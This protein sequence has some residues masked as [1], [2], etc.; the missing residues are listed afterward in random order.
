MGDHTTGLGNV[1]ID[2][3]DELVD[4]GGEAIGVGIVVALG[5]APGEVAGNRCRD[6]LTDARLQVGTLRLKA[7]LPAFSPDRRTSVGFW[8]PESSRRRD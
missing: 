1:A 6:D 7:L 2:G 4:L 3:N 5:D 8:R